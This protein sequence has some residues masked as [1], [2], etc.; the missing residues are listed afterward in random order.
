M[1]MFHENGASFAGD[2][3]HALSDILQKY[4]AQGLDVIAA[5][6]LEFTLV[7]D[8]STELSVVK[9]PRT[10]RPVE[11]ADVL[12]VTHMDA[13]DGFLTALYKGAEAMGIN[14]QTT[15]KESGI[16]QFEITLAPSSALRAA[17][18]TWLMKHLIKGTARQYGLAATFMA[19]PFAQEPGNGLHMHFSVLDQDGKNIFD[20]GGPEGTERLRAAVAGCLAAM[21]A[22]T[23]IFAP[24]ANSYDRLVPDHHAPTTTCWGYDNRTVA[25]RIPSGPGKARRIEHRVAGGDCNPYLVF[26]AVIGAAMAGMETGQT[27]PKPLSGNAYDQQADALEPSWAAAIDRFS[28]APE[29]KALFHPDLILYFTQTKRQELREMAQR[30]PKEDWKIYLE[31]V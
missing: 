21:P 8:T 11:I 15:T 28:Q 12:S 31:T 14:A 1:E 29:I 20:N 26:A 25:L 16:G 13:Y 17:D 2:A 22:S 27:P 10:N 18:D 24:H 7:D 23:L 4:T 9:D 30:D 5:T 6:E 3:R 19:K